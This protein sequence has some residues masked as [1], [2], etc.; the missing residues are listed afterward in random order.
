MCSD[1]SPPFSVGSDGLVLHIR[2]TPKGGRDAIDGIEPLSNGQ[3]VLKVRVRAVPED[4]K[5]N[6]A[7]I[8]LIADTL[9]CAASSIEIVSGATARIKTFK[10]VGDG[11][12]LGERLRSG[13]SL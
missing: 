12:A 10:I 7:L 8:K 3:S 11:Q 2:L 5:A 4:G 13:L 1:R 6:N 9:D